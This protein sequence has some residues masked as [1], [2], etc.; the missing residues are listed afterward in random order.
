MSLPVQKND[1]ITVH[2]EDL[3][4]DGA[5]VAKVNGY[6]LFIVGALPGEMAEVHVLKTLKSY[7]FAK[8]IEVIKPSEHRVAPPCHV[9][10]QCG[11]CQVQHLSYEGQLL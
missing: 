3:T 6:P 1:R 2:I 8:L 11:G 4:H 9:F 10:D 5:G 7:G